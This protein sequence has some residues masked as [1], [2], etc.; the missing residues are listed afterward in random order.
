MHLVELLRRG[1][2]CHNTDFAACLAQCGDRAEGSAVEGEKCWWTS[3]R[4]A[5]ISS[6]TSNGSPTASEPSQKT[7]LGSQPVEVV[8]DEP[9]DAALPE[10]VS[11]GERPGPRLNAASL[12][13]RVLSKSAGSKGTN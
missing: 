1:A 5:A 6:A 12:S 8:L 11:L 3:S 13:I 7:A 4:K 10:A 2:V 9:A